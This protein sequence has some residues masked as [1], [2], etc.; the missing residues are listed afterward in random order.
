[1]TSQG[2]ISQ[3]EVFGPRSTWP[4]VP[5]ATPPRFF[6]LGPRSRFA[7][8]RYLRHCA[9]MRTSFAGPINFINRAENHDRSVV[10]DVLA[11]SSVD[12]MLHA[13]HI[14]L[15]SA[16]RRIGDYCSTFARSG[17]ETGGDAG[18]KCWHIY[19][20]LRQARKRAEAE[21]GA[22]AV[23]TG[24]AGPAC[25]DVK[26][27]E[28]L[29]RELEFV[30]V[31]D[32]FRVLKSNE[33]LLQSLAAGKTARQRD[34]AWVDWAACPHKVGSGGSRDGSDREEQ[35]NSGSDVWTEEAE[36]DWDRD[37]DMKVVEGSARCGARCVGG[38]TVTAGLDRRRAEEV[39]TALD[40]SGR[41]WLDRDDLLAGLE[42]LGEHLD[43]SDVEQICLELGSTGRVDMQAFCDVVEAE[44]LVVPGSDAIFLRHLRHNRPEWC[45][46]TPPFLDTV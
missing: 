19:R 18:R 30:P 8:R 2:Q 28:Q 32:M 36:E 4:R 13:A 40:R 24:R 3:V 27:F 44:R 9:R 14:V 26:A 22:E 23:T 39:F 15:A 33:L 25:A 34:G 35:L 42:M 21:A 10:G 5:N 6:V 43:L 46:E 7:Y 17:S 11:T 45:T 1:M 38:L 41:G 31:E 12:E 29:L 16:E 37:K 20:S